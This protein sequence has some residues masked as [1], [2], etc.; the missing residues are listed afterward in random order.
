MKVDL[1]KAGLAL[2]VALAACETDAEDPS[3]GL[4]LLF[5]VA[6]A[7]YMRGSLVPEDPDGPVVSL[8][9]RQQGIVRRG[10]ADVTLQGRL[11]PGGW[12]I[13][14][15]LEDDPDHWAKPAG[16]FDFAFPDELLWRAQLEFSSAIPTGTTT[17]VLAQAVDRDGRG[18]PVR[19]TS[20]ILADEPPP[21]FLSVSLG[22]DSPVDLDLHVVTP[23]G[24]DINPKN[25]NSFIPPPPGTSTVTDAW[26]QGGR[27][28]FDSNQECVFDGRQIERVLYIDAPPPPGTYR[29]Y[30]HLFS[31][32]DEQSVRFRAV[33]HQNGVAGEEAQSSLTAFDA[34]EHPGPDDAPGLFLIEFEV[35]GAG[36]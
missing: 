31:A 5:R 11:G 28:D 7:Q 9:R 35:E 6:D 10:E 15:Q 14:F 34:R 4:H 24:I 27:H 25:V 21:S 29:V 8:I 32:C 19:R 23:D 2:L 26:R 3:P 13:H 22:W 36:G 30:A 17:T 33:V 12:A 20:F 18:G 16:V 1:R